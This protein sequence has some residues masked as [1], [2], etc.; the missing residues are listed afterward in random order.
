MVQ[1]V[2]LTLIS[3][4]VALTLFSGCGGYDNENK[5]VVGSNLI[6]SQATL[7]PVV[8]VPKA[9]IQAGLDAQGSTQHALLGV[10]SY[11]IDYRTKDA[12][13]NNVVASGLIT[14]PAITP[15]FMAAY[16]QKT[17]TD[18]SLS[19]VSDQHGTI[20]TKAE[21]PTA[22]AEAT[23]MPNAL[24]AAFSGV[25]G[26]MTVQPDYLGYGDSNTSHPFILEKPLANT[27]VDMIKAAIAFANKAGLPI[28]GQVFLSGYSEGGYATMAAAKEIQ[29]HHPEIHLM[30]VAPMAGPYDL[31]KIGLGAISAPVMAFPP[32]LA[33]VI[34]AYSDAYDDVKLS[35]IIVDQ[36][37]PT[38]KSLFD[39]EHN[40]TV[41]YVSLPNM[42]SGNPAD[43]A[44]GKLF[45]ASF[46]SNYQNDANYPLRKHFKENS[47]IDWKPAIPMKLLHCTNDEII[48]YGMSQIAYQKFTA[49]GATS[50]ELVPIDSVTADPAKHE[51]VHG[52]C[53]PVAYSQV[54]PWFDK[55][56]KGEK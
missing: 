56:R 54:I 34:K 43:Q 36:Y 5:N 20:F 45:K 19:I 53:A 52:K 7:T 42:L 6:L 49:A 12:K 21:A 44:P 55:I 9:V 51:T 40:A 10:K 14:I 48:P 37:L 28:N 50:V 33:F 1:R 23:H 46:M 15:D 39:G 29:E 41:A 13:G 16:K 27:T 4:V 30:A 3:G 47:P 26:F 8:D 2:K 25:A 11:K 17:G 35:D 24:S 22:K 18:F 31:E 38:V 32:Y